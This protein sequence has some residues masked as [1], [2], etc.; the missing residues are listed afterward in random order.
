MQLRHFCRRRAV[1]AVV[2][3]QTRLL[4]SS[5]APQVLQAMPEAPD[6]SQLALPAAALPPGSRT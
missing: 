6:L 4:A 5:Q 1:V 3:V 2:V